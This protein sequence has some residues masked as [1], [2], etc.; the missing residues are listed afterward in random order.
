MADALPLE[1]LCVLRRSEVGN[2]DSQHSEFA[3][4]SFAA[5][6]TATDRV[7]LLP[8][9]RTDCIELLEVFRR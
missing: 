8:R 5:L 1:V 6:R 7:R 3:V 9:R 2:S 4:Y